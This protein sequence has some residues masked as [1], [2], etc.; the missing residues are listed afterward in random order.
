MEA[1]VRSHR[2]H[3]SG[4]EDSQNEDG[5]VVHHYDQRHYLSAIYGLGIAAFLLTALGITCISVALSI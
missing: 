5:E 4:A 1:Q 3:E 2:S